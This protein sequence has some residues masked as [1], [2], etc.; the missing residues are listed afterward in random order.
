MMDGILAEARALMCVDGGVV[1]MT[2][3]GGQSVETAQVAPD[4]STS[5]HSSDSIG[6][7][8]HPRVRGNAA[9]IRLTGTDGIP[10]SVEQIGITI[11]PGGKQ[12]RL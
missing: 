4:R 12:R 1:R 9:F 11:A 8:V 2:V 10:W 7:S 3:R 5:I 6:Y